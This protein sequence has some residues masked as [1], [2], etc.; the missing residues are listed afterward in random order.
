[1]SARCAR[2]ATPAPSSCDRRQALRL[3]ALTPLAYGLT[4]TSAAQPVA[5]D[6]A[7]DLP[8]F[9]PFEMNAGQWQT[10]LGTSAS[11]FAQ[12]VARPMPQTTQRELQQL[13]QIQAQR[14]DAQVA[15]ARFWD[16]QGGIPVWAQALL[17]TIKATGTNPV[18]A[19][20]ALG[21]VHA[22]MA[23]ATV[24]AWN[25]K[26]RFGRRSPTRTSRAIQSLSVVNPS[27]PSYP[28]EHAAIATAAATILNFLFPGRRVSRNGQQLSF[29][30]LAA[31]AMN[32]RLLA[33]ANFAND[34]RAGSYLGQV[35]GQ[36]AILRARN[37]GSS[38][39]WNTST[40]PGRLFG[41]QHWIPTP[42]A[43]AP[44]P[45]LPLTGTW[46]PWLMTSGSQFRAPTP[47]ALQGTFPSEQFLQEA[48]EVKQLVDNITPEQRQIALF[49]ADDPGL[50]FTPPGHWASIARAQV[51][52]NGL[53][54]P[55]AAR[56]LAMC[57]AALADAGIACWDSKYAYWV[58]RPVTAIRT[59]S[60][61]PFFNPNF[62][63]V[64]PTPPFPSY[65]SGHSTFSGAAGKVLQALFPNGRVADAF[66]QSITFDEAADQAA[67][68]RLLGGIHYRS[69]NDEGVICGR[70]I[71]DLY[72]QRLRSDPGSQ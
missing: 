24:A 35:V 43:F 4:G 18:L 51:M 64:I 55:A 48:N 37:D 19:S 25:A 3:L 58:L 50:T 12:T 26:L 44:F 54:T 33:G 57:G 7:G 60:D 45:L 30:Q 70:H 38:A 56:A 31:E 20:R 63:T 9:E 8:G 11:R 32:S 68:S 41:P 1:M 36:Q 52:E 53:S 6:G 39:V 27:L 71:A 13:L 65:T 42:P 59:M 16:A 62:N 40:Q 21:L 47:P 29:D 23:D 5:R 72:I 15:L 46:R 69:D 2:E 66:G 10:W 34:V 17:D 22:A 61:Q 49:W 28:S 67:L 14:G